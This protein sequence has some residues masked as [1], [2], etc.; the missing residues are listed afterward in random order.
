MLAS[1]IILTILLHVSLVID[2]F[3]IRDQVLC[4]AE[5]FKHLTNGH[6]EHPN[7]DNY[8]S[9]TQTIAIDGN[10]NHDVLHNVMW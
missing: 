1:T 10:R 5:F 7:S 4:C 2:K 9:I 8:S 3:R 6:N